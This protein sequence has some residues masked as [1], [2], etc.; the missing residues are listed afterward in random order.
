M[1]Y[2]IVIAVARGGRIHKAFPVIGI[3]KALHQYE[4]AGQEWYAKGYDVFLLGPDG[5]LGEESLGEIRRSAH[6]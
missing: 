1:L 4:T 6:S 5:E 2:V 3:D